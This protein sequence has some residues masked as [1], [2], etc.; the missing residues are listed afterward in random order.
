MVDTVFIVAAIGLAATSLT[1]E[2]RLIRV[3]L[4]KR[5]NP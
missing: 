5:K 3:A 1:H 4:E 2:L